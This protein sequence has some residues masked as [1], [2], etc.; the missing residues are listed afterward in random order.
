LIL[1]AVL[2]VGA[3][4]F[5][6][7]SLTRT[8][9]EILAYREALVVAKTP[10]TLDPLL[11]RADPA[12]R[13]VG[14]LLY[15]RLLRLDGQASPTGDLAASWGVSGDGL[16]YRFTLRA[17]SRWS[18]GSQ[19][20]ARDVQATVALVQ[21]AGFPDAGLAEG[22]KDVTLAAQG[23][24][25]LTVTLPQPRAAFVAAAVELP[26]LPAASLANLT[27]ANAAASATRP[28]P[29][30]GPFQVSA[31]DRSHVRLVPNRYA[32]PQPALKIVDLRLMTSFETAAQALAMGQVDALAA[33]TPAQRTVLTKMPGVR[34]HD[35]TTF[36]F[37]DLLF[38]ERKPG[39]NDPAVRRAIATAVDRRQL[40][41]AG[42]GG[43]ARVQVGA[44][45][46]GIA[47]IAPAQQ[48]VPSPALSA[49]ALDAAGWVTGNDGVR[50]KGNQRLAFTVSVP[51]AV[52]LPTVAAALGQQLRGI[53]VDLTVNVVKPADFE[54]T[55]L[56][57]QGFDMVIADWD[58]GPDP[59][60][61]SFWRSN[62]TPPHGFNV[63]G[64]PPD[65][66]LDRALDSLATVS[67]TRLRRVAAGQVD[68]R[69][70]EDTPAVFLY[71]PEVTFGVSDTV[72]GVI[73]PAVGTSASR[74]EGV[75]AWRKLA[76]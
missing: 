50:H 3:G 60:V 43:D 7:A 14:Q 63:S 64:S 75:V 31:T 16:S 33:G 8:Q 17:D 27:G 74:Y 11:D 22:W 38:N 72:S 65:P 2:G 36:R 66:F 5:G 39:L 49:R 76:A 46:V 69:L 15:R 67:D 12:V 56:V 47:W 25:T 34:L 62:A 21:S 51:A 48:E 6:I 53:G 20:T 18:D 73:V 26:I 4:A 29:T 40:I 54:P 57:P 24:T 28:L 41:T 70:A 37:V 32:T 52:P 42:L 13:D 44:V 58:N 71:A 1:L 59:D 9:E 30:S 45:P 19:L 35:V 10:L 23:P 61:S 55:V 68:A